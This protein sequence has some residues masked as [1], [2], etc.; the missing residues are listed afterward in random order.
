MSPFQAN[1][2]RVLRLVELLFHSD[3]GLDSVDIIISATLL[4]LLS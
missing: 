4:A 3:P 2:A 1:K